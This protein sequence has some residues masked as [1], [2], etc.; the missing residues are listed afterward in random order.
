MIQANELRIGN[1]ITADENKIA[2]KVFLSGLLKVDTILFD[3]VGH[4]KFDCAEYPFEKLHPIPLTPEILEKCGFIE[5]DGQI[6][7]W[8]KDNFWMYWNGENLSANFG[9]IEQLDVDVKFIH[10][11]QNL[12]WCLCGKEL[13][14]KLQ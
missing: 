10:Q 11:L 3:G 1:W 5:I 2:S 7:M 13:E 12:Y 14:I 6:P 8:H 4:S 9:H